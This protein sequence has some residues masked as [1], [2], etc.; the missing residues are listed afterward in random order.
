MHCDRC[1]KRGTQEG[2][3]GKGGTLQKL[4]EE[5]STKG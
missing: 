1:K 3:E 4:S 5:K 2:E